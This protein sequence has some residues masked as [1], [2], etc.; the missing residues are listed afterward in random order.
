MKTDIRKAV[1]TIAAALT[2][3]AADAQTIYDALRISERNYE[4]TARTVAMGNAF[5]ALG[6]DLGSIGINPAGSAVAKYSQM[7]LT[8]SLTISSDMTQVMQSETSLK[9]R[10]TSASTHLPNIGFTI[11]WDTGRPYGL[12]NF[13]FGF[14]VN[15]TNSWNED[16]YSSDRNRSTSFMGALAAET[17][18]TSTELANENA[19][20][21]YIPWKSIIGYQS[22]MISTYGG[23]DNRYVG[24]SE[25]LID[26]KG[27]TEI[28]LGGPIDQTYGRRAGGSRADYLFNFGFN[29]SDFIYIGANLGI[30]SMTYSCNEYF[31]ETAVTPSDFEINLDNGERMYF[32]D[33]KYTSYMSCEAT[34]VYGK[35]GILITPGYG[36]RIGAAIQTPVSTTVNETW[37]MS[38]TTSYTENKYDSAASTPPG[39]DTYLLTEPWRANFGA[40]YTLGKFA[41]ISADYELCDYSSMKFRRNG[42]DDGREYFDER[43]RDIRNTFRTSHMFRAG[44]EVKPVDRLAIRAG[45]N[46][47]TAPDK[48]FKAPAIYTDNASKGLGWIAGRSVS[49]AQNISFGLGFISRKSFYA[50][51]AC[52]YMFVQDEYFMPY[53]NYIFDDNGEVAENA[54]APVI[55]NKADAWKVLLTLGWRF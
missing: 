6:G 21:N 20:Y 40:A 54:A 26:H 8:P 4:G 37:D 45:Y 47:T 34:G 42:H 55:L 32:R 3:I 2:A 41:V 7:A 29:I 24:A 43:N 19:Y 39:G 5:T 18:Y 9:Y 16:I 12:K 51:I 11:N 35:L 48:E 46:L 38:G 17:D 10:N 33:M 31:K 23:Y 30:S 27:V 50:D 13:T 36:L 25:V 14:V 44:L 28:A 1:L 49:S 22:G 53:D 15:Q 52:R